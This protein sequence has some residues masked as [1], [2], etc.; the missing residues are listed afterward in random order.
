[1]RVGQGARGSRRSRRVSASGVASRLPPHG[2]LVPTDHPPAEA[3]REPSGAAGSATILQMPHATPPAARPSAVQPLVDA[4]GRVVKD[5]R[6]SVTPRCNF[7]CTYCDPMGAG[8]HEPPGTLLAEHFGVIL[9]AAVGLGM[10]SVRYTGGEPLL[11]KDLPAL[12]GLAHQAFDAA[13][14]AAD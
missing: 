10:E 5:L 1:G 13:G 3:H 12:I 11:R 14:E 2:R 4:H 9:R 8:A 7:R 6:L